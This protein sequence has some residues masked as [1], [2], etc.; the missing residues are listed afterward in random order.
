MAEKDLANPKGVQMTED[1]NVSREE[2]SS[3]VVAQPSNEEHAQK[4]Q[5]AASDSPSNELQA[6]NWAEARRKMQ[7]LERQNRELAES[8]NRLKTP[9]K[10]EED[11]LGIKDEDLVEGKHLKNL[12]KE[13]NDLKT[14]L[15]QKEASSVDDRLNAKFSDY[16]DVVSKENIELLKQNEPELAMSLWRL[17]DDPYAQ[18]VA[19]YK[20]LKKLGLGEEKVASPEKEKAVKNSQ[21]PVSVNA[22]T[23]Q[24]AI[25]NAHLF[26]NGLTPELKKSLWKEMQQAMK[27]A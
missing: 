25:G 15:Q 10:V 20:L 7:E 12:K 24:S 18:G 23:K 5:E 9:V 8:V 13:I 3:Q 2:E 21:K 16:V 19:A 6:K 4:R 27:G 11:D 17:Q 26:E 1:E 14:Q 22:V